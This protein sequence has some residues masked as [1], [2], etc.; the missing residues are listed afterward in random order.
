MGRNNIRLVRFCLG[1]GQIS[2]LDIDLFD[3]WRPVN[4]LYV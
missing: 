2:T 1:L 4:L 3:H